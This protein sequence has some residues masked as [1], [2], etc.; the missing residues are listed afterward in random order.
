MYQSGL[1]TATALVSGVVYLVC[2]VLS[3]LPRKVPAGLARMAAIYAGLSLLWALS[4]AMQAWSYIAAPGLE[5]DTSFLFLGL[6]VLSAA[7]LFLSRAMFGG[8]GPGWLWLVVA[9]LWTVVDGVL[10][11]GIIPQLAP[12]YFHLAVAGWGLF[13]GAAM[14]VTASALRQP[15]RYYS[16][17]AYWAVVLLLVV[18]GDGLSFSGYPVLGTGLHTAGAALAVYVAVTPRLSEL[19]RLAR[20][21][22]SYLLLTSLSILVFTAGL[23][24]AY[25]LLSSWLMPSPL[26]SGL[27]LAVVVVLIFMP[28]LGRV[29]RRLEQ[30]SE[31]ADND[32]SSVLRQYSQSITNTLDLKLLATLAVGT[33]SEFLEISRGYLLLVEPERE[34]E[35]ADAPRLYRLRGVKG[36]GTFDPEAYSIP[37]TSPLIQYLSEERKPLTQEQLDTLARFQ[38]LGGDE[39]RWLAT[40]GAGVYL[41]IYS[42]NEWIG[43]LILGPKGDGRRFTRSDLAFLSTLADQTGVALENTRLVDGLVRLNNEFRRAYAALDQANRNL[44]RL[45]KTKTNFISIASHELRTPLTLISGSTQMLMDEQDLQANAYHFQLLSKIHTGTMRLHQVVD[46][47]LDIAMI[48]MRTLELELHPVSAQS[49][50]KTVVTDLS[51]DAAARKLSFEVADM[52]SLPGVLADGPA[53]RKVFY[54]IIVN[55]VKYTPDGGRVM[56][57]GRAIPPTPSDWPHGAVEVVVADTGIGIDPRYKELIFAKFY[58]TGELALHSSGKTKFKGGGPGLG[59][60]IAKGIVEAHQGKIWAES[61]GYDESTC[62]GSKF[63]VVLPLRPMGRIAEDD[64]RDD[65]RR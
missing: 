26:L 48:D 55:A 56:I 7:F 32:P 38:T 14:Y 1:L 6:L 10:A 47:M 33:A 22:S 44:E 65:P 31:G 53:L 18:L 24:L 36:M 28:L 60:A 19:N 42:K 25:L 9:G 21:S 29:Q 37:Q 61:S 2:L 17:V 15:L 27:L 16:L 4:V 34:I 57:S 59:L 5:M 58:Q 30:W 40:L 51:K 52:S 46:S 45:D 11:L 13:T 54:H 62:P 49:L 23:G 63:H 20:R 50:I 43:L 64:D 12:A 3:L 8:G 35:G 41:P 39:R